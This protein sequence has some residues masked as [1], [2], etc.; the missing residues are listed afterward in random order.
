MATKW[1]DDAFL[2]E[3]RQKSDKLADA[4]VEKI[5]AAHDAKKVSRLFAQMNSNDEP[6]PEGL[7][8]EAWDF[9]TQTHELAGELLD[10][11]SD[12]VSHERIHNGEDALMKHA[13]AAGL[14][15][16]AKSMLE[17][18]ASPPLSKVLYLSGDLGHHPWMRLLGTL[19]MVVNVGT[20]R[21]FERRGSAVMT[22]Q[23]LRLLHAG[24]RLKIVPRYLP[25][26]EK[27]YGVPVSYLVIDGMRRLG[28]DVPAEDEEDLYYVWQ[29]FAVLMGIHP[30]GEP[31]SFDYVPRNVAEAAE[32]YASYSR[33]HYV[34][35]KENPEGVEL[36]QADLDMLRALLPRTARAFGLGILPRYYM[37]VLM[38]REACRRVRIKPVR[39]HWL[40]KWFFPKIMH[41]FHRHADALP[42]HMVEGFSRVL[43]Q[44]II[45][46]RWD[47]QVYY[48]V[49]D[50]LADLRKLAEAPPKRRPHPPVPS[51]AL[52]VMPPPEAVV[53]EGGAEAEGPP[54]R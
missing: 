22:T 14:I 52:D 5:Y 18:Y 26:Y 16:L 51:P 24:I 39:G 13:Y 9:F 53:E 10:P 2:D 49:P 38:D 46:K 45:N 37:N 33:R 35:A 23:K 1:S 15:Y 6:L 34:S 28:L 47:G 50:S 19:Q 12:L 20:L 11:Q 27:E 8:R 41:W 17:G 42:G 3:L 30:D 54:P 43:F 32:F 7:P 31:T 36:A 25:D 40:V 29:V 44:G 4:C 48:L 21:G